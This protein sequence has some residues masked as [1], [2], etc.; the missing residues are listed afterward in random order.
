V[1]ISAGRV[2]SG[3]LKPLEFFILDTPVHEYNVTAIHD[4]G[5]VTLR[6]HIRKSGYYIALDQMACS[7]DDDYNF[8]PNRR[9]IDKAYMLASGV[10]TDVILDDLNLTATGTLSSFDA[11]ALETEIERVIAQ[12]MTANGELSADV[13]KKSDSSN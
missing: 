6:T 4:K 13:T 3:A 9:V 5:F 12:E 7:V 8:L 11:A 10:I 1:H 2:R